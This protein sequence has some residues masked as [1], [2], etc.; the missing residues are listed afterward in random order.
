MLVKQNKQKTSRKEADKGHHACKRKVN[1]TNSS[2][3]KRLTIDELKTCS[4]S[5]EQK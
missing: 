4:K 5:E 1:K 3:E 2:G